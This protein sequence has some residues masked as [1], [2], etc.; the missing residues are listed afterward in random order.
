MSVGLFMTE[1]MPRTIKQR[2]LAD[3]AERKVIFT[4][5]LLI[6]GLSLLHRK[7]VLNLQHTK[8]SP[9]LL[10]VLEKLLRE[11]SIGKAK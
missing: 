6:Y 10:L 8:A 1:K 3:K 2:H 7:S 4:A 11:N 9:Q 5:K